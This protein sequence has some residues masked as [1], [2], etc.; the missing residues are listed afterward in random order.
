MWNWIVSNRYI[1]M[2]RRIS[3]FLNT[4][5]ISGIIDD[6]YNLIKSY[7]AKDHTAFYSYEEFETGVETLD[8]T[9]ARSESISM[10]LANGE[11]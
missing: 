8:I 3:E 9:A 7:V 6:A 5:N 2:Y 11:T 1:E 4:V 10:Q